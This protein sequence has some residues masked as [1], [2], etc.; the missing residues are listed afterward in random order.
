MKRSHSISM[1]LFSTTLIL[2]M[3]CRREGA[4]Q[5]PVKVE[6]EKSDFITGYNEPDLMAKLKMTLKIPL[7]LTWRPPYRPDVLDPA[8]QITEPQEPGLDEKV[9]KAVRDAVNKARDEKLIEMQV[10]ETKELAGLYLSFVEKTKEQERSQDNLKKFIRRARKL[11]LRKLI[12]TNVLVVAVEADMAVPTDVIVYR[13]TATKDLGN[14]YVTTA[15]KFGY[16]KQEEI[17]A[18]VKK[19]QLWMARKGYSLYLG[20]A[21]ARSHDDL[22][23]YLN[24]SW[25]PGI[26]SAVD[27]STILM[28]DPAAP[29]AWVACFAKAESGQN[30]AVAINANGGFGAIPEKDVPTFFPKR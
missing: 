28:T 23:K 30:D 3:G 11:E 21:T 25:Y 8:T 14:M 27:T 9:V 6:N 7:D 16:G 18:A 24:S 13:A 1:L 19:Q 29:G 15:N 22:K 5:E 2:I 12:D 4:P 10:A 17:V 26:G 20:T